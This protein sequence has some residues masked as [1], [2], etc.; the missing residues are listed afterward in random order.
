MNVRH[1][2]VLGADSRAI[3]VKSVTLFLLSAMIAV[4]CIPR[5]TASS[6]LMRRKREETSEHHLGITQGCEPPLACRSS[7]I[8]IVRGEM[9]T[10]SGRVVVGDIAGHLFD[11]ITCFTRKLV[12]SRSG[13]TSQNILRV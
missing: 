6:S 4:V 3:P 2:T 5:S 9:T 1:P 13:A 10:Q 8:I 11:S 12:D 7:T